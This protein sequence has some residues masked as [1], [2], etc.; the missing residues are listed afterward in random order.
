MFFIF[1]RRKSLKLRKKDEEDEDKTICQYFIY[2]VA[3]FLLQ[4]I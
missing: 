3:L 1:L 4:M 2:M